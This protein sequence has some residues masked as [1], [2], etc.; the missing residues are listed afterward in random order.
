QMVD[1]V[2]RIEADLPVGLLVDLIGS[3]QPELVEIATLELLI[4]AVEILDEILAPIRIEVDEDE[5]IEDLGRDLRQAKLTFVEIE[6]VGLIGNPLELAGRIVTPAMEVA[7]QIAP[8]LA[9]LVPS[10]GIAAMR[11]DVMEG[12]DHAVLSAQH[13]DRCVDHRELTDEIVAALRD[14]A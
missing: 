11:A 8:T 7:G 6:E 14:V 12:A 4:E 10:E 2:L 1:L 13:Q 3:D 5:A 9:L